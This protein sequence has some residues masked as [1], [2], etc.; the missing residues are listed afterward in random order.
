MVRLLEQY[1]S[2]LLG[3]NDSYEELDYIK[4]ILGSPVFQQYVEGGAVLHR[5]ETQEIVQASV[6]ILSGIEGSSLEGGPISPT[7]QRRRQIHRKQSLKALR[8]AVTPTL[9]NIAQHQTEVKCGLGEVRTMECWE[10]QQQPQQPFF[11]SQLQSTFGECNGKPNVTSKRHRKLSYGS[12]LDSLSS[13][14]SKVEAQYVPISLPTTVNGG[15][16]VSSGDFLDD[17]VPSSPSYVTPSHMNTYE[18]QVEPVSLIAARAN[19]LSNSSNMLIE[20]PSPPNDYPG[21]TTS[22]SSTT[23][24]TRTRRDTKEELF[25]KEV[26]RPSMTGSQPNISQLRI[27]QQGDLE[28]DGLLQD[29]GSGGGINGTTGLTLMNIPEGVRGGRRGERRGSVEWNSHM[30]AIRG[31]VP[32]LNQS[33]PSAAGGTTSGSKKMILTPVSPSMS[34][35]PPPYNFT[36]VMQGHAPNDQTTPISTPSYINSTQSIGI[37]NRNPKSDERLL[38][39]NGDISH[40]GVVPLVKPMTDGSTTKDFPTVERR[41]TSLVISLRKGKEGLGFR[42]EGL[43]KGQKGE[44][45]VQDIQAGGLADR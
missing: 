23:A 26:G 28:F 15:D 22:V 43:I 11:E 16:L 25:G 42:V 39:F 12:K 8:N 34:R 45:Y 38:D 36:H 37:K 33:I 4:Q 24:A 6:D 41:R 31:P 21:I 29:G 20:R 19:H 14:G 27:T 9:Q 3:S 35:P 13:C 18:R 17:C 2:R 1:Q 5:K 44:L 32:V 7:E 40:P 30:G 10:K